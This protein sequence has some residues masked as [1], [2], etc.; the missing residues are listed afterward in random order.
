MM[1]SQNQELEM[2]RQL[3]RQSP[4]HQYIKDEN[5]SILYSSH[6]CAPASDR[7]SFEG[8]E[9]DDYV[10]CLDKD[11]P[12]PKWIRVIKTPY[13][14]EHGT[15]AGTLYSESDY[16]DYVARIAEL[17]NDQ[18]LL[19]SILTNIPDRIFFKD[20]ESRFI[21]V[22]KETVDIIGVKNEEALIGKTD[23]DFFIQEDAEKLRQD[24]LQVIETGKGVIGIEEKGMFKD[25]RSFWLSTTK[26]P[27]YDEDGQ[28]IGTMGVSR[29]ITRLKELEIQHTQ[30]IED[31]K[32]AL[33]QVKQLSGL[34]PICSYCKKIRDDEGYWHIIEEYLHEQTA[35]EFSH[36]ICDSCMTHHFPQAC[37]PKK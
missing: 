23:Y 12:E 18:R 25:G 36:G 35:A 14:D 27:L 1:D 30:I 28:I 4:V 32:T 17:E 33:A 11:G 19:N 8:E 20:L 26:V 10:L 6:D 7:V 24:E 2:M 21:R 13:L 37:D 3:L 9:P 16:S 31:L 5:G 15:M 22:S 34:V 29:D